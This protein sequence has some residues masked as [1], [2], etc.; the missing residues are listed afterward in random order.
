MKGTIHEIYAD[1]T[2]GK[3]VGLS[4]QG[5]PYYDRLFETKEEV[6]KF[7]A[8]LVEIRDKVFPN[9]GGKKCQSRV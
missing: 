3:G 2:R 1:S 5:D 9:K 8:K 6:D 7:I 4:N